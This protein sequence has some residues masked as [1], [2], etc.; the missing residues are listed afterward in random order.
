MRELENFHSQSG[1]HSEAIAGILKY[2][3]AHTMIDFW[4]FLSENFDTLTQQQFDSHVIWWKF[5]KIH[6][7]SLFMTCHT[8]TRF[9]ISSEKNKFYPYRAKKI[10]DRNIN[11]ISAEKHSELYQLTLYMCVGVKGNRK[12]SLKNSWNVKIYQYFLD[13]SP[14]ALADLLTHES[15]LIL[16][17]S[18]VWRR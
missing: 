1:T 18:Y 16:A 2:P 10:H 4:Y 13:S 3:R 8:H 15:E 11:C 17:K 9:T 6:S 12:I 14:A 5:L 7:R